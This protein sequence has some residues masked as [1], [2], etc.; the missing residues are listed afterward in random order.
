MDIKEL[1][2]RK[3]QM[4]N[5]IY[6][7]IKRSISEFEADTGL[8]PSDIS[9]RMADSTMMSSDRRKFKLASVSVAVEI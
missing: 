9:V 7:A 4:Q 6:D 1:K 2:G 3:D 8:T 5:E